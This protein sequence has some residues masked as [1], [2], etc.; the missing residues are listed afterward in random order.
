M[1]CNKRWV[2]FAFGAAFA[3]LPVLVLAQ[4]PSTNTASIQA[5]AQKAVA[6]KASRTADD[7]P[8]VAVRSSIVQVRI[9]NVTAP[10]YVPL[11]SLASVIKRHPNVNLYRVT[12][13][14]FYGRHSSKSTVLYDR[15][16]HSLRYNCKGFSSPW[17][18]FYKHIAFSGVTDKILAKDARDHRVSTQ[19]M[20]FDRDVDV[21]FDNLPSYGCVRHDFPPP[22]APKVAVTISNGVVTRKSGRNIDISP[23]R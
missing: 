5:A 21:I 11:Q 13:G 18:N 10:A 14:C 19:Q 17:G 4:A 1:N 2:A 23:V 12:W 16:Q 15:R 22:A 8:H 7:T 20:P 6:E 9:H 3:L